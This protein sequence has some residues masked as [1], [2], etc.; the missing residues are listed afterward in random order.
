MDADG[1]PRSRA[2]EFFPRIPRYRLTL[3]VSEGRGGRWRWEVQDAG[4]PVEILELTPAGILGVL[5]RVPPDMRIHVEDTTT[6]VDEL[7]DKMRGIL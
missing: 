2:L 5:S 7:A 1:V 6:S 3:F 4:D